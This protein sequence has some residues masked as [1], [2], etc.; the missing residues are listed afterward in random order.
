MLALG[1]GTTDETDLGTSGFVLSIEAG[2]S[3]EEGRV[4]GEGRGQ[5]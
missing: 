4:V 3:G 5:E 1:L 2:W